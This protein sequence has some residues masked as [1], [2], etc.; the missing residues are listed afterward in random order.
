MS[1]L[2]HVLC[3]PKLLL[4]LLLLLFAF[5]S[6]QNLCLC[7]YMHIHV[8][9]CVC[10]LFSMFNPAGE[11]LKY[12]RR[13]GSD[14]STGTRRWAFHV[15]KIFKTPVTTPKSGWN[16]FP[17]FLSYLLCKIPSVCFFLFI[18]L[19]FP[20]LSLL[21]LF[22]FP[23][24][25]FFSSSIFCLHCHLSFSDSSQLHSSIQ[26]AFC[27]CLSSVSTVWRNYWQ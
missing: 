17:L 6:V 11:I 18:L 25:V 8:C 21:L 27:R 7:K 15:E 20:Y 4:V 2:L 13:E 10:M 9:T 24:S 1:Y 14:Y 23:V 22:S 5:W 19:T 12:Y 3:I 16:Y 26:I